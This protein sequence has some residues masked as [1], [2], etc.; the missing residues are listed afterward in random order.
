MD[1]KEK[2]D[3][4]PSW[5]TVRMGVA[6]SSRPERGE[7]SLAGQPMRPEKRGIALG[8]IVQTPYVEDL[9]GQEKKTNLIFRSISLSN[10]AK[11]RIR[12]RL[13]A[14]YYNRG[15]GR[16]RH[17]ALSTPMV[18]RRGRKR[19]ATS[20]RK[21]SNPTSNKVNFTEEGG[22]VSRENTRKKKPQYLREKGQCS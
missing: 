18:P 3:Q 7:L 19:K 22:R 5:H 10:T 20:A 16:G 15:K 2:I 9:S 17:T 13:R 6:C 4:G 8:L 11:K 14:R 12:S 21:G 1:R